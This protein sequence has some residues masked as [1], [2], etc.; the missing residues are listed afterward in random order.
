MSLR[1]LGV[2]LPRT[3]TVSLIK[4]LEILGLRAIH[5]HPARLVDVAERGDWRVYDDVDAA[6]DFP[7]AAFYPRVLE[8]YPNVRCILTVRHNRREW[9]DSICGFGAQLAA[10]IGDE[11]YR[12]FVDRTALAWWGVGSP[13]PQEA[14]V[15]RYESWN[16][17]VQSDPRIPPGRLLVFNLVGG[18]GWGPLCRFL[19]M[20]IPDAPF[21]WENRRH[22]R[23]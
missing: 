1:I 16:A 17:Q 9:L 19:G 3:G 2:G 10:W 15:A 13:A 6:A 18:D 23:T 11:A 5:Y 12:A 4:A 20:P 14:L 7:A 22:A 8:A 21:P